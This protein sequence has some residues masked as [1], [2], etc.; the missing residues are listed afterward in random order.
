MTQAQIVNGIVH[1]LAADQ[2]AAQYPLGVLDFVAVPTGETVLEGY[3]YNAATGAF[4]APPPPPAPPLPAPVPI[5]QVQFIGL[6]QSAGGMT[7]TQIA[8]FIADT[9][10][11][12]VV[13]RY[14]FGL[15]PTLNPTDST[16]TNGLAALQA[17]TPPYLTTAG[18]AA[19]VA[20]WPTSQAAANALTVAS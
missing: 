7:Q 18:A 12:I 4:S 13:L 9:T 2:Q 11:P 10:A 6:L 8:A 15:A 14:L 16:V 3:L 17:A 1:W 20:Q 5:T 19:V